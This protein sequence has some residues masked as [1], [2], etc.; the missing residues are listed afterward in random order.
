MYLMLSAFETKSEF[1]MF[2]KVI[3][4]LVGKYIGYFKCFKNF[5][6]SE[7]LHFSC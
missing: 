4:K 5:K 2:R 1:L 3:T 6:N 7:K